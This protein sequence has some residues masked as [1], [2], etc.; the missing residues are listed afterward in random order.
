[1][2]RERKPNSENFVA[3]GRWQSHKSKKRSRSRDICWHFQWQFIKT[4]E[5]S[6]RSDVSLSVHRCEWSG[7]CNFQENFPPS[8]MWAFFLQWHFVFPLLMSFCHV[9]FYALD[10]QF[11][12]TSHPLRI[13]SMPS[14]ELHAKSTALL[15]L[16]PVPWAIGSRSLNRIGA[17]SI[18]RFSSRGKKNQSTF[19]IWK[20]SESFYL[21][22][23]KYVILERKI[24][25][26]QLRMIL[27]I[28]NLN[29]QDDGNYVCVSGKRIIC[30]S[31]HCLFLWKH[32]FLPQETLKEVQTVQLGYLVNTF[33]VKP[34]WPSRKNNP[35]ANGLFLAKRNKGRSS[36]NTDCVNIIFRRKTWDQSFKKLTQ[37]FWKEILFINLPGFALWR[38]L[39]AFY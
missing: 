13:S 32:I 26:Y 8:A 28:N 9:S 1:M 6:E 12:P 18:R 24:S 22:S 34:S 30:S 10:L 38:L 16:F 5:R 35:C 37:L 15:N 36:F 23:E 2:C 25:S 20:Y 14:R 27:T 4:H 39:R 19:M 7:T 17:G 29:Q 33:S 31:G 21:P 11:R 3:S